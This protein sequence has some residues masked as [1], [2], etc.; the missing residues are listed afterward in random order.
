MGRPTR[1]RAQA[2]VVPARRERRT[3]S[4]SQ[5]QRS[6]ASLQTA[7]KSRQSCT[8]WDAAPA[9]ARANLSILERTRTELESLPMQM[10]EIVAAIKLESEVHGGAIKTLAPAH[11]ALNSLAGIHSLYLHQLAYVDRETGRE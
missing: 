4:K 9:D 10:P 6:G 2:A 7:T 11:D 5:E 3:V 8:T 1:V